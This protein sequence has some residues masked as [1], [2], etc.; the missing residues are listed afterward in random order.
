MKKHRLVQHLCF[1]L[2]LISSATA[3]ETPQT[4]IPPKQDLG[5]VMYVGDSITH[6]VRSG[7]YRRELFKIFVDNGVTQKE[8]GVNKG[9]YNNYS[10]GSPSYRGMIFQNRHSSVSS[11]RAYEIAGRI[12]TSGRLGNS[13]IFDW[14]G[15]D[16][17]YTGSFKI[18]SNETP[19]TFFMM[20]GTND[21]LADHRHISEV[22]AEKQKNLLGTCTDGVWDGTGDMDTIVK[23]MRQAN[24]NAE[25]TLTVIP[26]WVKGRPNNNSEADLSVTATYNKN[27]IS[28]GKQNKIAV[29]DINK[30]IVDVAETQYIGAGIASMFSFDKLHPSAQGDLLIA[31]NLAKALGYRGRTIGL[32]RKDAKQFRVKKSLTLT[33]KKPVSFSFSTSRKNAKSPAPI[34]TT[35]TAE[36]ALASGIGDGATNGWDSSTQLTV[37]IGNG[38]VSGSLHISESAISWND[39]ILYSVDTSSDLTEPLRIAY[40]PEDKSQGITGGY[41]VWLGVML[42]GEALPG[43]ASDFRGITFTDQSPQPINLKYVGIEKNGSFAP[44]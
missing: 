38:T 10:P 33:D 23:A 22:F 30:G 8:V 4:T 13:N 12:N 19:D 18:A 36:F 39:R 32:E 20:I 25:I 34:P 21:L 43:T 27:L 17:T 24:P 44:F 15:L 28:W 16:D 14:L 2:A 37:T 41:C 11:E 26:T 29:I 40:I 7:S 3:A 35:C 5:N 31:G 1:A 9:H 6:G 42:I